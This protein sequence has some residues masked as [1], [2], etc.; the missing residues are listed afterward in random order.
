MCKFLSV[1]SCS[2]ALTPGGGRN[3]HLTS[4]LLRLFGSA[5]Q[6]CFPIPRCVFE[7]RI[8][9]DPGYLAGFKMSRP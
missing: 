9:H 8:R 7:N 2:L 6:G 4:I 3:G 1:R 5:V